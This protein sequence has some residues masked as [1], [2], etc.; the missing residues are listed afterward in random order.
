M[1]LPAGE[2]RLEP[3][4]EVGTDVEPAVAGAPAQPFDRST[5]GEVDVQRGDV[6]RH[7]PRRLIRV[8]DHVRAHLVRAPDDPFDVLD[9]RRLEED[10]ADRDE[11]GALVD[12][13]HDLAVVLADN[14]FEVALRLVEVA[15]GR[16]VPALVDDPVPLRSGLEAGEDDGLGDRDVLVHHGRARRCADDAADLVSDRQRHLP[17]A[18]AP[19]ADS[20]LAPRPCV[21]GEPLFHLRRHRRERVVDQVGRVL[22]D[23]ELGA[24]VEQVA[25]HRSLPESGLRKRSSTANGREGRVPGTVPRTRPFAAVSLGERAALASMDAADSA[26]AASRALPGTTSSAAASSSGESCSTTSIERPGTSCSSRS[27]RASA[28]ASTSGCCSTTTST[29]WSKRR[30]PSSRGACS[31]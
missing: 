17:P 27:R 22:E 20:A 6:E 1:R 10:V 4:G 19:G 7:D 21:L 12:R 24:V 8:E 3:L 9:L 14:D 23:R 16:E 28:G 15:D 2:G 5:D 29:S 26:L 13:L 31:G 18:L 30:N 25:H 11:Q